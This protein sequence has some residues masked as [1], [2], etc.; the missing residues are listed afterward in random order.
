MLLLLQPRASAS[1]ESVIPAR[2]S[3]DASAAAWAATARRVRSPRARLPST[4][5]SL[6]ITHLSLNPV[7]FDNLYV[8]PYHYPHVASTPE[9][10]RVEVG[11]AREGA[12]LH[13]RHDRCRLALSRQQWWVCGHGRRVRRDQGA[14]HRPVRAT[15]PRSRLRD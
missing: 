15:L 4:V 6:A 14:R 5:T 13:G 1:W 2:P 7:R 8:R 11:R 9:R 12:L 3:I 10:G